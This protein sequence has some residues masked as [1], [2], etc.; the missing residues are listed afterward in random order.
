MFFK[1][2]KEVIQDAQDKI[3]LAK[4]IQSKLPEDFVKNE[5]ENKTMQ[6]SN[7]RRM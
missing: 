6:A 1:K 3:N 4:K 7:R 2:N 5:Q